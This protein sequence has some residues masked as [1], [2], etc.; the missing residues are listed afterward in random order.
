[1][2]GGQNR[3]GELCVNAPDLPH[4]VVICYM[5]RVKK[6]TCNP[7]DG[8]TFQLN[9]HDGSGSCKERNLTHTS[10]KQ[11]KGQPVF[12]TLSLKTIFRLA[13]QCR[14]FCPHETR[15]RLAH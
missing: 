9:R 13:G 12:D 1:M 5:S 8:D 6:H 4:A 14:Y 2:P 11:F 7:L 15:K 3:Q 10:F